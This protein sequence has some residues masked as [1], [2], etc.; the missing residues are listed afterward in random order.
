MVRRLLLLGWLALTLVAHAG[1]EDLG[2]RTAIVCVEDSLRSERG[3]AFPV[4]DGRHW[5]T[6]YHVVGA[7]LGDGRGTDAVAVHLLCAWTG[8]RHEAR[9]VAT[10]PA[11]DLALLRTGDVCVPPLALATG[12]T[13][14]EGLRR[15]LAGVSLR[16]LGYPSRL[17]PDTGPAASRPDSSQGRLV[18]VARRRG[19]MALLVDGA[20]GV[21]PG[22]SGGPLLH[23]E[24]VVGV[25]SGVYRPE[26]AT[27]SEHQ[28][29][30][31]VVAYVH[32]LLARAGVVVAGAAPATP[33]PGDARA[34]FARRIRAITVA[35]AG[36][37]DALLALA[38]EIEAQ[39]GDRAEAAYL[40]GIAARERQAWGEAAA[41]FRRAVAAGG[42]H[43]AE[44]ALA[45]ALL[46]AGEPATAEAIA[47]HAI[48][49]IAADADAHWLLARCQLA[50]GDTE[51]AE[52]TLRRAVAMAPD[53]PW[54]RLEWGELLDRQRR[55]REALTH[56]AAAAK[57]T[58]GR[59]PF[60]RCQLAYARAAD[61]AGRYGDAE[62]AYR[63]YR[64]LAP[65]DRRAHF[66]FA[67][68]LYKRG[69]KEQARAEIA[70]LLQQPDLPAEIRSA[71]EELRRRL[72]SR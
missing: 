29:A 42:G 62:R 3:T 9:L 41:E 2:D 52:A 55:P 59:A 58:V 48:E 43:L 4:A 40:R 16:L 21:Q 64:S 70:S 51:A 23:D 27:P 49:R 68:L 7:A 5:I 53:H 38:A 35:A 60:A 61:L 69:R 25:L 50:R 28:A 6:A 10:D 44:L 24:A 56:L 65:D 45:W 31:T 32:R 13:S 33:R 47:A 8:A 12:E 19:A 30:A 34:R 39:E 54:L 63:A 57:L 1:R 67:N 11:A 14:P 20:A 36:G 22:W 46:R 37:A 17:D 15:A 72:D 71:A 18:E 26:G 66:H